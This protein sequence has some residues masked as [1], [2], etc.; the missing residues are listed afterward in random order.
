MLY[1]YTPNNQTLD[2]YTLF[3]RAVVLLTLLRKVTDS[4]PYDQILIYAKNTSFP[5]YN[6]IMSGCTGTSDWCSTPYKD[7]QVADQ[8]PK[9]SVGTR[10]MARDYLVRKFWSQV[11]SVMDLIGGKGIIDPNKGSVRVYP[12]FV[13]DAVASI[14]VPDRADLADIKSQSIALNSGIV[15]EYA[16]NADKYNYRLAD[17]KRLYPDETTFSYTNLKKLSNV[18]GIVN[19]YV[20]SMRAREEFPNAYDKDTLI[21][22]LEVLL[23]LFGC[24]RFG[25]WE[26]I[27]TFRWVQDAIMFGT[28]EPPSDKVNGGP[29]GDP[30][31]SRYGCCRDCDGGYQRDSAIVVDVISKLTPEAV[32]CV[33]NMMNNPLHPYSI[34]ENRVCFESYY[35]M[36]PLLKKIT[37]NPLNEVRLFAESEWKV[38]YWKLRDWMDK[39]RAELDAKKKEEIKECCAEPCGEGRSA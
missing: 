16:T 5:L 27:C 7:Y 35:N 32:I 39:H 26:N 29:G 14:M 37:P 38:Q 11:M 31:P 34:E 15:R 36:I 17:S 12:K 30:P 4:T 28:S 2:E 25:F 9:I 18:F 10:R 20:H 22:L 23:A 3:R 8:L 33:G 21:N 1:D 19:D 24:A 6:L 13:H